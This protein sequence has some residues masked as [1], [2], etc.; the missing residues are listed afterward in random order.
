MIKFDP[1]RLQSLQSRQT[2]RPTKD[3]R[4]DQPKGVQSSTPTSTVTLS[5]QQMSSFSLF[6]KTVLKKLEYSLQGSIK[7]AIPD[8]KADK[9]EQALLAAKEKRAEVASGNIL[10]FIDRQLKADSEN[11]ASAE[12][13]ASRLE[14]AL[15]GYESGFGEANS[16]LSDMGLMSEDVESDVGLTDS[17]VRDGL[18]ALAKEYLGDDAEAFVDKVEA[19]RVSNSDDDTD[20]VDAGEGSPVS[21][22]GVQSQYNQF[23]A[24]EGRAFSFKLET[25]DGDVVEINARSLQ[26]LSAEQFS[27]QRSYAGEGSGQSAQS[28]NAFG[29]EAGQQSEFALRIDGDLDEDELEAINDLLQQVNSLSEDFY[30]GDMQKALEKA[31]SL[32]YDSTEIGSFSVNLS[33]TSSVKAVQAYQSEDSLLKPGVL[34]ELKPL[35]KFAAQIAQSLNKAQESFSEPKALVS[36]L[37]QNMSE[38]NKQAG[39]SS[40]VELYSFSETIIEQYSQRLLVN[41]NVNSEGDD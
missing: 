29:V 15:K 28:F 39:R 1:N 17:K 26:W 32:G 23:S 30:G 21:N 27:S 37:I 19:G 6:Q 38:L 12:K 35:G 8:A 18:Q 3:V 2:D 9:I 13:I 7:P 31:L 11:G 22:T 14:A 5:G 40:I 24:S 4:E 25:R 10:K 33:Q 34:S 41:P 20:D 16:I 36:D